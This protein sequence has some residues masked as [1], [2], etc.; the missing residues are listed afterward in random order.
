MVKL[1]TICLIFLSISAVSAQAVY[2]VKELGTQYSQAQIDQAFGS[3]DFCGFVKTSIPTEIVLN[4]G[5]KIE[6]FPVNDQP[7]MDQSCA[8]L[9]NFVFPDATWK[10][11]STGIVVRSLGGLYIKK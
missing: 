10:I 9:D 8:Q 4:D 1:I 5:A 7:N 6:L 2:E 11:S 3:A